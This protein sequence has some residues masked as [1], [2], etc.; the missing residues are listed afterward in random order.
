MKHRGELVK[1]PKKRNE[2]FLFNLILI[3]AA[4]AIAVAATITG[5]YTQ[6][7]YDIKVGL[8]AQQR[9]KAT[10]R[11]ENTI[12]TE[13][14]REEAAKAAQEMKPIFVND[15]SVDDKVR[16]NVEDLFV[17]LDEIR[18]QYVNELNE[19]ARKAAEENIPPYS[20]SSQPS[21]SPDAPAP[22]ASSPASAVINTAYSWSSTATPLP[23][24]E[25]SAMDRL[26]SLQLTLSE[27]QCQQLLDLDDEH[28]QSL[29]SGVE[30]ALSTVLD[31]GVQELDAKS[32][33]NLQNALAEIDISDYLR[34]IAYQIASTYLEPN[35]VEDTDATELARQ[36]IAD[37]YT[38]V[39]ILQGQTIVD[40][41]QIISQEAYEVLKTLGFVND[42][43]QNT[44][45]PASAAVALEAILFGICI[46]Y[47]KSYNA[48]LFTSRKESALLFTL[49]AVVVVA[50]RLLNEA[51]YQ[52]M[53]ILVFAMLS[54][55]LLDLRLSIVLSLLVTVTG[56]FITLNGIE[57][58][59]FYS[60]TSM[61][62]CLLAKYT[63]ERNHVFVVGIL[64]SAICF[65]VMFAVEFFYLRSYETGILVNAGYAAL[66]GIFTVI[67]CL[68]SLPF[69]EVFF[70]VIT[71][72][73]LLDLTNPTNPLLRK[74][75]IEA[76]GTYQ[77]SLVV[78]NLAETAAYD[79]GA[80]PNLARVGGYY[81]DIGK[82]KYPQYFA[83]NQLGGH[84]PH[85]TMDPYESAKVIINHVRYGLE[86]ADEYRLPQ[87]IKAFIEQH[88]GTTLVQYFYCK[89]KDAA[90]EG[91]KVNEADFR[92]PFV[93]PQSKETAVLMLA[94]TVEAAV[95]SMIKSMKN[96]DEMEAAIRRLIRTK[97]D[98]GQLLDSQLSIKDLDTIAKS[99][100]RV[101]QGM[102]HERIPYP[103][104]KDEREDSS[105]AE[106]GAA[107]A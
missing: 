102:Y 77:H 3:L 33:L 55:M 51:P 39:Y 62:V 80:D 106:D 2:T 25:P 20:V 78:A 82:T 104:M 10:R 99:F 98:D 87:A 76:P 44:L 43:V 29:K 9:F 32:L 16:K 42:S 56:M 26:K 86:L 67:L 54:A 58:F 7:G 59:I 81:H 71:N 89:A 84:N 63:T 6:N 49:F 17:Q 12:A 11:V 34:N 19:A 75:T 83:E 53:P 41:G 8:P 91:E 85:D 23:S 73:K 100:A 5:A 93:I 28:Y 1:A 24:T 103:K 50:I 79:I 68:G 107:P 48:K 35:Y 22:S 101:L 30:S 88:H 65:V 27:A 61:A 74:L 64:A 105:D 66:N 18:A 13:R 15:P 14:N 21:E 38:T 72:I 90:P 36:E 47:I 45:L 60:I 37:K 46:A 52:F 40:E 69:W 94:D 92:Y 31:Q 96:F 95:R 57:F 4:F 70:G 97:L